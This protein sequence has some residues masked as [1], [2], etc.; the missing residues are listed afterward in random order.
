MQSIV[1]ENLCL[2]NKELISPTFF[3]F[4]MKFKN[5]FTKGTGAYYPDHIFELDINKILV[6]EFQ[7]FDLK[8][9]NLAVKSWAI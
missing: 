2:S 3:N 8:F 7:N 4:F 6:T 9:W 1:A 5:A